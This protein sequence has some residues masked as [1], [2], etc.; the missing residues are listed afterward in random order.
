MFS[1]AC[2]TFNSEYLVVRLINSAITFSNHLDW[3]PVAP[4]D[5]T[6]SLS[7]NT[8]QVVYLHF[9]VSKTALNEV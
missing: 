1:K 8:A 6:S 7:T 3:A 4:I 5:P 9:G 2:L